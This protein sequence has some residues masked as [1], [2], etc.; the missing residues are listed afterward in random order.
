MKIKGFEKSGAKYNQLLINVFLIFLFVF[1]WFIC[2][3]RTSIQ[4]INTS[5]VSFLVDYYNLA[6]FFSV[7]KNPKILILIAINPKWASKNIERGREV[8]KMNSESKQ[9]QK[10]VKNNFQ[11]RV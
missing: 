1:K 9:E 3:P 2:P 5:R 6:C 11:K 8:S 7:L 10:E 4:N